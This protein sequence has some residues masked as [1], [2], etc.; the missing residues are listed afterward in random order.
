MHVQSEAL[1]V[2]QE[3][4]REAQQ[5]QNE[6]RSVEH[7]AYGVVEEIKERHRQELGM[8][9]DVAQEAVASSQQSLA[10]AEEKIKQVLGIIDQQSRQLETQR[11]RQEELSLQLATLQSQATMMCH[12]TP[13]VVL[14]QDQNGAGINVAELMAT[15]NDLRREVKEAISLK[16]AVSF[17]ALTPIARPP[18]HIP[19]YDPSELSENPRNQRYASSACA[20]YDPKRTPSTSTTVNPVSSSPLKPGG[21]GSPG[22]SGSSS[23]SDEDDGDGGGGGSPFR[24]DTPHAVSVGIGSGLLQWNEKEILSVEG[25]VLNKT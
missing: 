14:S 20:G 16:H 17:P 6:A 1:S 19:I 10:Q 3:S 2:V 13:P 8:V 9:Q 18:I 15:V 11:V 22:S 7:R 4:Q 21:G 12:S 25:P 5:A 23:D 24:V